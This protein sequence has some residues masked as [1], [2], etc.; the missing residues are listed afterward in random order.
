MS[1]TIRT[2]HYYCQKYGDL[3]MVLCRKSPVN[4]DDWDELEDPCMN[5]GWRTF[6]EMEMHPFKV[7]C[8][9]DHPYK[10]KAGEVVDAYVRG[11]MLVVNGLFTTMDEFKEYFEV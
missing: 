7:K 6:V 9:K 1:E 4:N 10:V 8:K 5:C 2:R 3:D 11:D